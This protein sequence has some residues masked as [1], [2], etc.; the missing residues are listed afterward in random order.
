MSCICGKVCHA[1]YRHLKGDTTVKHLICLLLVAALCL[2][3]CAFAEEAIKSL[4]EQL[5]GEAGEARSFSVDEAPE[6]V[7]GD[8]EAKQ[9]TDAL[10]QAEADKA[11][12]TDLVLITNNDYM[13]MIP[14]GLTFRYRAPGNVYVLTQDLNQQ[15][16]LFAACYAS[17]QEAAD[18]F[19]NTNMHCNIYDDS[20][21]LDIYLRVYITSLGISVGNAGALTN[22]EAMRI[23][24]SMLS[25][26]EYMRNCTDV[27]YGWAGGNMWFVGDRRSVDN[28]VVLCTFVGGQEI[29][30]TVRATT[31]ADYNRIVD[32][33]EYLT[34][35]Y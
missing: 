23:A 18:H 14:G 32:L 5:S 19:I 15:S 29:F 6:R 21:G 28:T 35:S 25:S 31:D 34:I 33:L 20:T 17:P 13:V 11:I 27:S 26:D 16:A 8:D 7:G 4:P 3:A 24:D 12:S 10:P 30:S 9:I 2:G 1:D 22:E